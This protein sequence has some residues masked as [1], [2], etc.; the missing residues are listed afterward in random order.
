MDIGVT[1]NVMDKC[2]FQRVTG[3]QGNTES[4]SSELHAFQTDES[5]M[6]P[7]KVIGKFDVMV[8]SGKRMALAT[9]HVIKGCMNTEP[10]IGFKTCKDLDLVLV[11]NSVQ[12]NETA[13]RKLVGE[14]ADLFKG[15]GKM[16]GVQVDLDIDPAILPVVQ[17]HRGPKL[18]VELEKLMA[19]DIIEKV[20]KPTSWVSPVEITLKQSVNEIR[21]NVEMRESNKTIPQAHTVVP[22]LDDIIHKLNGAIVFLHLDMNHGYHQL[23]LKENGCDITTSATHVGLY[24]YKRLNF[25]TK[26]SGE[27]FQ[28]TVNKE[29]TCYILGC[30]NI[31][32]HILV[33]GKGQEEH[34]QCLEKLF[35]R[36]G[37]K[38]I[39]FNKDK[40]ECNK[41]RCLY[42]RMVF[43]KE[44]ASPDPVKV[45]AIKEAE[46]LCNA[47]ELH[48]FLCTVQYNAQFI[49]SYTPVEGAF[50]LFTRV[51]T[52]VLARRVSSRPMDAHFWKKHKE[53]SP[54]LLYVYGKTCLLDGQFSMSG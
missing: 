54:N 47:K 46:P 23:E 38:G 21:L 49:E 28:D 2:S 36:A 50:L 19:D 24:R 40:C 53:N 7:L 44:G 34:D 15:I 1:V 9:F 17:P 48:S 29:I 13:V 32:D 10:L 8:E 22:T 26:L 52:K 20:N 33:F 45:E 42:Y 12:L 39:T 31:G 51:F 25:G 30:S 14:Y 35:K 11:A 6:V 5:P 16:K 43:S 18:E 27:I 4:I 37:E 3:C 41:D